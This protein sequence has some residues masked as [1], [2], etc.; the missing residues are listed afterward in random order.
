MLT[1]TFHWIQIPIA[2]L[3]F[4]ILLFLKFL[5]DLR[6]AHFAVK[7]L[8][9]VPVRSLTREN[10][11]S[12]AGDWEHIWG[13]G[14]S[15]NFASPISRH[16]HSTLRQWTSY[17]YAEYYSKGHRYA[18][19]GRVKGNYLVGDWFDVNDPGG[20]FG[21]FQLEIVTSNLLKGY[22][23]GHSKYSREIRYDISEWRKI[24]P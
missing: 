22:W 6:L 15:E 11:Q 13:S 3:P 19:F 12:L 8:F 23:L 4:V 21:T 16:G 5:L 14:G 18:F 17:C 1:I 20:Y 7:Y 9:W 2:A 10:P 24:N